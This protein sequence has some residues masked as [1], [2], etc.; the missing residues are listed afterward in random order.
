MGS[1]TAMGARPRIVVGRAATDGIDRG[2]KGR[3]ARAPRWL[4]LAVIV[5]LAAACIPPEDPNAPNPA[6]L[7]ATLRAGSID[8]EWATTLDGMSFGYEVQYAS[9]TV[10]WTTFAQ[11][12]EPNASFI[13]VT[14]GTGYSFRVRSGSAPGAP[15]KEWSPQIKAL[16]VEPQL[17]VLRIDTTGRAPILDRENYVRATMT[18]EPNGSGVAPYTGTLDVRGR[19]NSTWLAPK[20]P[21]R[22]RLDTKSSLMGIASNRHWALLANYNDKSQLRSYAAGEISRATELDFTPAYRHVE[23]ILNGKY[24]GVYQLTEHIRTGGDRVD[25]EEMGPDDNAGVELTGGYLM[26]IDERLEQNFEPGFRTS[27]NVPVVVKEPDPMTVE[28]RAYISGHV[29][30]FESA[31]FSSSY[32]DPVVGYRR[33]LDEQ[34]FADHYLVHEIARNQDTFFSS[35]FFTK[36]RGDDRLVFGP[37]WDFDLSMG[38]VGAP[39]TLDA[40]GWAHRGTG[41]WLQRIFTDPTFLTTLE[42]RWSALL[43]AVSGLPDQVE[44][45]GDSLQPAIDNDE[46]RWGYQLE[47]HDTPQY[48]A[49]WLRTRL[50]WIGGEL[51]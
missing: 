38:A 18:L 23:V 44:A 14:P 47:S 5:A 21:Y 43:P 6:G 42:A 16:Y 3:R 50:A 24:E 33:Y 31:L 37:M 39:R 19:G 34:A 29:A 28:Q 4:L 51:G 48:V 26:E 25:I 10:H 7:V 32:T 35:T 22:L 9:D 11:T 12:T 13:D 49:D 41:P 8:L 45:L 2:A 20:K 17:P 36:Q 27:R 46:V 40:T 1:V 15:V 30:A